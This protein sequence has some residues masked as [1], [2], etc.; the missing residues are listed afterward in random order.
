[1]TSTPRYGRVI[2]AMVTP[3]RADGSVDLDG[4][5]TLADWLVSQGNDALVVTGTTG[6]A[7]ALTDNEKNDVWRAVRSSVSV[8]LIAGTSTADTAHSIELTKAAESAGMDAILAVTPYYSRP[9]QSG[10]AQHFRA[11][12][13]ST[14]LPV[15][16]YDIPARS[17]RKLESNTIVSV[18]H[19]CPNITSLKDAAGDIAGTAKL[20]ASL[21]AQGL[22]GFEIYS[23][24]DK[25][26][27]GLLSVGAVGVV[28]VA[29]HW[30]AARMGAMIAV[31]FAGDVQT[32][33]KLNAALIESY[34]FES[35]DDAP[36]PIPTK[37]I[38]T[39]LGMP[40]G[41]CRLPLGEP[42]QAIQTWAQQLV[43]SLGLP[44]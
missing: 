24:E 14:A 21:D 30:I 35:S 33:R 18:A 32:A 2:T 4:A 29:T 10:I 9:S 16:L 36:N 37:A 6:E 41:T 28:G 3:M 44:D 7:T 34:E 8:P 12:A 43:A 15:M 1:M 5:A 42:T 20:R 26:T 31:Y 40:A 25:L 11:M 19:D 39:A 23:G 27:L 13:Q 17:G 38:L 22:D